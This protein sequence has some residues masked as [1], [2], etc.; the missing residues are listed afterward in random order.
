MYFMN[1]FTTSAIP[2]NWD[3]NLRVNKE[4]EVKLFN[5]STIT[6]YGAFYDINFICSRSNG[7]KYRTFLD[8]NPNG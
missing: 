8:E 1:S 7:Q 5:N 2:L 4:K 6:L 3:K